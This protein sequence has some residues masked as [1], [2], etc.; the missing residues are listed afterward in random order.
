MFISKS[1][2]IEEYDLHTKRHWISQK[3]QKRFRNRSIDSSPINQTLPSENGKKLKVYGLAHVVCKKT[4]IQAKKFYENFT[5]KEP[6][7]LAIKNFIRILSRGKKNVI[8]NLQN[9]QIQKMA[10][11]IGSYPI[12]G[13]PKTVVRKIKE[14]KKTGI[15][16]VAI[17]FLN[18]KNE[19]PFF[20]N[21]VLKQIK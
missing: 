15:D 9:D 7:I 6:D 16:G 3:V 11:G 19:L 1:A 18:Y 8:F 13:S 4:D 12:I 2:N 14:I 21:K 10:G 17:S 5:K 20:I